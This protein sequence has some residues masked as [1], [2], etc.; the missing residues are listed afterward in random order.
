MVFMTMLGRL[1]AMAFCVGLTAC[2]SS[3]ENH[4][5]T[6]KPVGGGSLHFL[7]VAG[8][9]DVAA[10]TAQKDVPLLMIH[11]ASANLRDLEVALLPEAARS[12]RVVLVDRPGHGLSDRLQ[13]RP[14]PRDQAL[15][16][17]ALADA[18]GLERPILV[19]NS[20]GGAVALAY[21][22]AFPEAVSG[23][24]LLAPV[25]HPWPGGVSWHND[26]G[27][28]PII[29]PIF[30]HTL[31]PV[32][33]PRFAKAQLKTGADGPLPEGY[34]EKARL[35]LLF[36]PAAFKAN[37]EDLVHLKP[38]IEEQSR[39]YGEL[40][41]PIRILA[42]PADTTVSTTIHAKQL[43]DEAQNATLTLHPGAGH[44]IQHSR[45]E[46]VLSAID[47]LAR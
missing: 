34:Y 31:V 46:E 6:F 21:G 5:G 10:D 47:A 29:G 28:A 42:D 43:V 38:F 27:A 7:D 17:K 33:G 14:D 25:S 26:V 24:V 40:A 16:I 39:R 3:G 23:M 19:A 2:A 20:Y 37:S 32:L 13:R 4:V 30:R 44:F 36:R 45:T 22:L 12:R 8:D 9:L 11:G 35:D 18:L 1:I 41:M 15:A